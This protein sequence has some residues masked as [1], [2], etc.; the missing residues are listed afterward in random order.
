MKRNSAICW[1]FVRHFRTKSNNMQSW[2][3]KHIY[4]HILNTNWYKGAEGQSYLLAFLRVITIG[5]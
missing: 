4:S 5:A 2:L 1:E 3:V